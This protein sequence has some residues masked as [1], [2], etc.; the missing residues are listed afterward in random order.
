MKTVTIK[1]TSPLQ[2][3]GNEAS[4]LRR[5]SF[6]YP[7]K[8]AVVGMIAAAFGYHRDDERIEALSKLSYA[9]RVDQPGTPIN[10]FHTVEWK[11]G[12]RKITYR[13]YIQ[14]AIFV[15]AVGSDDEQLIDQIGNKLQHPK[16]QLFL[17]RRANVP[18]G[19]IKLQYFTK[20]DPVEALKQ[21]DWQA[22]SWYGLKHRHE[23]NVRVDLYADAAML[24]SNRDWLAKDQVASFDPRDR[25]FSFRAVSHDTVELANGYYQDEA[26][27]TMH[28]IWENL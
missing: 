24:A 23:Q 27:E 5:T 6:D 17:G 2:S 10:D 22:A 7:S 12:T 11:T 8:S 3:Y 25:Q 4:F 21:L 1:L 18:A 13:D 15:A 16:F 20:Q 9:V 26:S 19:P 28:D 14:D